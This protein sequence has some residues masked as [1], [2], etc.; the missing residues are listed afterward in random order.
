MLIYIYIYIYIYTYNTS[1]KKVRTN[2]LSKYH[3]G[4]NVTYANY[5]TKGNMNFFL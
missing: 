2:K 5:Q 4:I 3:I 1:D